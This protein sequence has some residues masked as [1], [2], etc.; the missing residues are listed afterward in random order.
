MVV[1]IH[2]WHFW[3]AKSIS[4]AGAKGQRKFL[5]RDEVLA[6]TTQPGL[7]WDKKA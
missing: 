4:R 1:G 6:K 3:L 7:Q 5:G 2:F